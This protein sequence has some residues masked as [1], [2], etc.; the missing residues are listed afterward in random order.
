VLN[1]T[2]QRRFHH[3][4]KKYFGH[5][6]DPPPPLRLVRDSRPATPLLVGAQFFIAQLIEVIVQILLFVTT[7]NNMS[8]GRSRFSMR[9]ILLSS[10]TRQY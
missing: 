9:S 2:S 5:R 4:Q 10:V 7:S 1:D 6:Q 8:R 3:G